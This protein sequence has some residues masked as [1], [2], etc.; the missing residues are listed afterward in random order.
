MD[1][2]QQGLGNWLR[3]TDLHR[4]CEHGNSTVCFG[5]M[6]Q[7]P[8]TRKLGTSSTKRV[9]LQMTPATV[10]SRQRCTLLRPGMVA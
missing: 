9:G 7:R 5:I 10:W 8:H 1:T 6:R 2:A 4:T 3:G